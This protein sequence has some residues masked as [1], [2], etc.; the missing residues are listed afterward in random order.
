MK[1]IK[2]LLG[3][4]WILFFS[5]LSNVF[6]TWQWSFNVNIYL[7]SLITLLLLFIIG[8]LLASANHDP[9]NNKR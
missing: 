3:I 2:L 1:Y 9:N 4:F 8:Y 7:R 5:Y 6:I